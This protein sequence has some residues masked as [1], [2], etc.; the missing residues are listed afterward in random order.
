MNIVTEAAW[1]M[2]HAE[3]D[4]DDLIRLVRARFPG[5]TDDEISA[6]AREMK[7]LAISRRDH[8]KSEIEAGRIPGRKDSIQ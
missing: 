8:L 7:A 4:A 1:L 3:G 6:A 2:F 5:I